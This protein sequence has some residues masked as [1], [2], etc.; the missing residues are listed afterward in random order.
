MPHEEKRQTVMWDYNNGLVRITP[1]FKALE[2]SKVS[3]LP[4]DPATLTD[5]AKTMPARMLAKNPGL[6]EICHSITGGSLAAQ[7]MQYSFS[8]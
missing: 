5:M 8:A 6:R 2:Y 4:H 1:F 3:D 7:G